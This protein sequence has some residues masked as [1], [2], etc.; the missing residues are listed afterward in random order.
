MLLVLSPGSL[1]SLDSAPPWNGNLSSSSHTFH[2][3]SDHST[4][5]LRQVEMT[6][7]RYADELSWSLQG[8]LSC[9]RTTR[10]ERSVGRQHRDVLSYASGFKSM[11][12][13]LETLLEPDRQSESR[14]DKMRAI[15]C[16]TQR[17]TNNSRPA[18]QE[19]QL[20]L[21]KACFYHHKNDTSYSILD[22]SDPGTPVLSA[23]TSPHLSASLSG[24]KGIP[25]SQTD[26][27]VAGGGDGREF[28]EGDSGSL[29]SKD[30]ALR[31]LKELQAQRDLVR[32][33]V[34]VNFGSRH[35]L[36]AIACAHTLPE[37]KV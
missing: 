13:V 21:R 11:L 29:T 12:T 8:L 26:G 1:L 19:M 5:S 10:N 31:P 25:D 16:E 4:V 33:Q 30:T 24:G 15:L 2:A 27:E 7:R 18:L 32:A 28:G 3:R 20:A 36:P 22:L 23:L 9:L 17:S 37:H 34:S 14:T 35:H 6:A